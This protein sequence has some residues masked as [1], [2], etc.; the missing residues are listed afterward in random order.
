[1]RRFLLPA[2]VLL[3]ALAAL[4]AADDKK[5]TKVTLDGLSSTTPAGWV[6]EKP[7]NTMRFLQMRLPKHKDDK[8]DA[9]LVISKGFGG[10][11]KDNVARWKAQFA[12]PK[13]KK[14]VS[15]E[16]EIKIGGHKAVM[17]D[18]EGDFTPPVFNPK[19]KSKTYPGYRMIGIQWEGPDTT[20]HFKLTGPAKTIEHHKKDFDAWLKGFKK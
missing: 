13:G 6:K 5:G 12:T 2:G 18:I 15:K 1:M 11:A 14:V 9:E 17:L 10:S 3:A 19:L 4:R 8:A 16:E 20:Y 7:A